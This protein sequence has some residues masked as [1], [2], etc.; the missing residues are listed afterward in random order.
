MLLAK[1]LMLLLAMQGNLKQSNKRKIVLR[2]LLSL[3]QNCDLVTNFCVVRNMVTIS[4][5]HAMNSVI[6]CFSQHDCQNWRIRPGW[7][8]NCDLV[9]TCLVTKSYLATKVVTMFKLNI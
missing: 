7:S 4:I 9:T 8:Q 3:S 1:I 5:L 6:V 2:N